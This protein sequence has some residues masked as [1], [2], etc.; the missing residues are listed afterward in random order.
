MYFMALPNSDILHTH[1]RR[2]TVNLFRANK[3]SLIQPLFIEVPVPS[4]ESEWSCISVLMLAILPLSTI[5]LLD[6]RIVPTL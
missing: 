2:V 3:T 6:F 1:L 4:Q 5:F